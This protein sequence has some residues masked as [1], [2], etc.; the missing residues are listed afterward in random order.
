MKGNQSATRRWNRF[1]GT[2][3]RRW[4]K[5]TDDDLDFM[6]EGYQQ[7]VDRLQERYGLARLHAEEELA[8]FLVEIYA[9]GTP[10]ARANRE[11]FLVRASSPGSVT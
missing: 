1:R 2:V 10:A 7:F 3:R 6:A 11:A 8:A 5:L 9:A 4:R